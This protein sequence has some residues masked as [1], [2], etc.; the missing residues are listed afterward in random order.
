MRG[1]E[2]S[3][4]PDCPGGEPKDCSDLER[5]RKVLEWTVWLSVVTFC[6][7]AR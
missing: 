1:K 3:H 6:K 2:A 5:Q 7:E 4:R